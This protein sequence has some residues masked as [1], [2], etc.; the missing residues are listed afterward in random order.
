MNRAQFDKFL[1][2]E[3]ENLGTQVMNKTKF[4]N[5]I[6]EM[7]DGYLLKFISKDNNIIYLFSKNIIDATGRK[8]LIARKL[9][10]EIKFDDNLCA[11][12]FNFEGDH[13]QNHEIQIEAVKDGWWYSAMLPNKQITAVFFTDAMDGKKNELRQKLNF[14][15]KLIEAKK[16]FNRV[17]NLRAINTPKVHA[18]RSQ[19]IEPSCAK[20]WAAA[21]DSACAF[22]PLSGQGMVKALQ[23]G[24][25]AAYT[26]L[27]QS[28]N[29]NLAIKKYNA[30]INNI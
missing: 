17:K 21:G 20:G 9:G 22:D 26:L 19:H 6:K 15:V 23:T 24:I 10:A 4:C 5:E 16:T 11:F 8:A 14:T 2:E 18:V 25:F 13:E 29:E 7:E 30:I 28:E 12:Q 1:L 3:A 27:E